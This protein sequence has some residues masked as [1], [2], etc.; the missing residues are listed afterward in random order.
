MSAASRARR[1]SSMVR[2]LA[3]IRRRRSS[4]TPCPLARRS[5]PAIS[6]GPLVAQRGQGWPVVVEAGQLDDRRRAVGALARRRGEV[7]MRAGIRDPPARRRP[8]PPASA[9]RRAVPVR[10][11]CRARRP[12]GGGL[13]RTPGAPWTSP[14]SADDGQVQLASRTCL[15]SRRAPWH[16]RR[17]R[18]RARTG[19]ARRSA[20]AQGPAR[21]RSRRSSS[22]GALSRPHRGGARGRLQRGD[23]RGLTQLLLRP[24][25][26]ARAG[27][28]A[29][30]SIWPGGCAWPAGRASAI[31]PCAGWRPRA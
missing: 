17:A 8:R 12:S 1:G 21:R 28:R 18:H 22:T 7:G 6:T 26:L 13:R 4:P 20:E 29:G 31:S 27:R 2:P 9:L 11:R 14:A 10:A 25:S 23:G 15:S 24:A 3:A 16:G 19:T 5:R 30:S